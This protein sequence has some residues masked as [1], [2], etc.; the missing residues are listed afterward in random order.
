MQLGE[1]DAQTK[2]Q[3]DKTVCTSGE[4]KTHSLAL[5]S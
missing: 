5:Q 3:Q 4:A 1:D 2:Q